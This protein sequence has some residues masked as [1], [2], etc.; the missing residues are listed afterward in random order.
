MNDWWA[1]EDKAVLASQGLDG[2]AALWALPLAPVD[3]PNRGRGGFSQVFRLDVAGHGYYLKRQSDYLTR[4]LARP[5]GEPTFARE[6]RS[7]RRYAERGIPALELA[8]YGER[9]DAAGWRAILVTRALDD[10][11]DL[12]S[13]LRV[14]PH[15]SPDER[16]AVLVA[17]GELARQLHDAGQV[18][19]CFYPKHLFLQRQGEGLVAR[20]I[21]L[22]KTRPLLFGRRDRLR[23]LEPLLR[24]APQWSGQDLAHL[25]ASYLQQPLDSA[26]VRDWSR[27]LAGR[28]RHKE[29]K[30]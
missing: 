6:S 29:R 19:G 28:R 15:L 21:D 2:F 18:H 13:W 7:I 10:W 23:D 12:D 4:T 9:R 25:L 1:A 27:R 5:L 26:A 22:E 17:V 3:E 14:W 11:R 8:Y 30:A 16:E 20:L 24:R